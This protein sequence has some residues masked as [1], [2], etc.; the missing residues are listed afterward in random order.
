MLSTLFFLNE[1]LQVVFVQR[2]IKLLACKNINLENVNGTSQPASLAA[3]L[4][5]F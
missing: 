3:Q 5:W 4:C 2:C 1:I